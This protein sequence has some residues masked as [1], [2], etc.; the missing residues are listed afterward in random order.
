MALSNSLLSTPTLCSQ[1]SANEST[2][3]ATRIQGKGA[4]CRLKD[5]AKS[6]LHRHFEAAH[7]AMNS[8]LDAL[9][10]NHTIILESFNSEL[11]RGDGTH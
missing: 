5:W 3:V 1:R 8:G 6:P 2:P 11:M 4:R 9:C 7:P 10:A